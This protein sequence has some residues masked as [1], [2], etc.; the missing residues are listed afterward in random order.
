MDTNYEAG[1]GGEEKSFPPCWV[2][3]KKLLNDGDN[4]KDMPKDVCVSVGGLGCPSR[5][6]VN[7]V[8][9]ECQQEISHSFY[10]FIRGQ[11]TTTTTAF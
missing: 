5:Q 11:P 7:V 6:L 4:E 1:R 3:S 10:S 2:S 9:D 8:T